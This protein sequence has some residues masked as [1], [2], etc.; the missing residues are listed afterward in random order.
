MDQGEKLDGGG[1]DYASADSV[2]NPASTVAPARLTFLQGVRSYGATRTTARSVGM[3]TFA[4][5]RRLCIRSLK[6]EVVRRLRQ[7]AIAMAHLPLLA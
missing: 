6:F 1:G 7:M 5:L 2:A 3:R 4:D